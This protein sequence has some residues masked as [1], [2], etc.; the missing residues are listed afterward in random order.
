MAICF[1]KAAVV[2]MI[3]IDTRLAQ[4]STCS[5]NNGDSDEVSDEEG[6]D[7]GGIGGSEKHQHRHRHS[8][9]HN[10]F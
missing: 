3:T 5:Y 9:I 6:N 10:Y 1:T 7:E 4:P 8:S 2:V